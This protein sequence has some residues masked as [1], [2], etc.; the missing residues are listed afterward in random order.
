MRS[1]PAWCRSIVLSERAGLITPSE[2]TGEK[3][4]GQGVSQAHLSIILQIAPDG[5]VAIDE[6]Q[7]IVLFNRAAEEIFGYRARHVLGEP[8][9][10]LLPE[11]FAEI[12]WQHVAQFG[13]APETSRDMDNRRPVLGRRKDGTEFPAEASISKLVQEGETIFVVTLRD[14][15]ARQQRAEALRESEERFRRA[16]EHAAFGMALVGTDGRLL[17]VNSSVCRM[18]GYSEEELLATTFQ[19]LTYPEDLEV[20]LGLFRDLM[21]GKRDYGWL[22]K[23]YVHRDGHPVWTLLSTAVVRDSGGRIL[24]LVSQIQDISEQK[25]AEAKLREKEEQ[26]R[27]IFESTSDGLFI[28]DLTGRL[29]DFNPAAAQMHGYTS[30]EFRQLQPAQ[31]IHPESRHLFDRYIETIRAGGQYRAQAIDVRKDG[32][33]FY[34]EVIGSAF[35]YQGQPHTLA[36]VRDVTDQVRAVELLEQRVTERTQELAT[37]LE[38]SANITGTLEL[39]PL[40]KMTLEQLHK[41]V[42]YSGANVLLLDGD[43]LQVACHRG[44]VPEEVATRVRF[45]RSQLGELWGQLS[46]RQPLIV[47]DWGDETPVARAFRAVAQPYLDG[48]FAYMRAWMGVPL[49]AGEQH[50]GWLSLEHS[51]PHAYAPRHAA[52][53]Q[54]IANQ[55]AVAIENA[56]LYQQAQRLAVLE[57][58]QRLARELHDSVT[59]ALYGIGLGAH[60]A[61]SVLREELPAEQ[62]KRSLAEPLEYVLSL[63]EAA[64]TEMRG[65]IFEMRPD[66]L[67]N[68]GLVVALERQA[69]TLKARHLLEVET[70][71]CKEPP[72]PF[73]VKEALYRITSEALNNVVRH[74]RAS[75]VLIQLGSCTETITLQVRDDGVGFDPQDR[76]LGHLGLHS[77]RERAVQLGGDLE[78]ESS[79]G[80]GTCITVRI[81]P[82]S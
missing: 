48:D 1:A 26:Y 53:A 49:M 40:L 10:R 44:P 77:M 75:R 80:R 60:T 27:S 65:L 8:V 2:P 33:P 13:A 73:E 36:V 31:F 50:F 18:L 3:G 54:T 32:T 37:L 82:V 59:Q 12:H 5:I 62:L 43:E 39:K 20:G 24:Y 35:T 21:D 74:A 15:T 63:A 29:V 69:D 42:A 46:Q 70:D 79:P 19:G 25:E 17:R 52:L 68:E 45:S 76:F 4:T 22:E 47:G 61:R 58:R 11:R 9:T 41:V 7:R 16:F 28:N 38:V 14:I 67:E 64:L 6:T 66:S 51:Q 23:R 55:A 34:V 78:I 57:E 56:R 71:L 81:P 72:L 30:D